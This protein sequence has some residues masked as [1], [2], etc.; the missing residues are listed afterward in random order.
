[1]KNA[2]SVGFMFLLLL[3]GCSTQSLAVR[4]AVPLVEAQHTALNQEVDLELAESAIPPSL[5]MM[6]GLL[7]ENPEDEILLSSLSEGFCNYAFGFVEDGDPE[8]ASGFYLRGRGYAERILAVSGAPENLVRQKLEEFK[9]SLQAI[10]RDQI[11]GLFWLG[12][13]WAGWLTLNLDDLGA[14]ADISRVEAVIERTLELDGSYQYAGPHLL[15]G[16]FYGGR[17]KILGGNP[18]KARVHFEKCLELTGHKFLPAQV[19]Y[20]KTYA[21]QSQDRALFTKLLSEVEAAP[22]DILPEQQLANSVAKRKA[23]KLLELTDELF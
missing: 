14:F 8:R 16:A 2:L 4:M 21:V 13:C 5:K 6:E 17:T 22:M 12:R 15:A 7:L 23:R 10:D 18:E 1:M 20:A 3:Q 11:Q 9:Q 19:M